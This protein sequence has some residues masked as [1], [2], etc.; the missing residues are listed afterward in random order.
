MQEVK[1]A[2]TYLVTTWPDSIDSH[3]KIVAKPQVIAFRKAPCR[4]PQRRQREKPP[5]LVIS[6]TVAR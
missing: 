3:N 2:M 5:W 1:P 4:C 6:Q